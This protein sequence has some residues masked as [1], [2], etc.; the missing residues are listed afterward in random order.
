MPSAEYVDSQPLIS[1]R[2]VDSARPVKIIYIGAGISGIVAGIKFPE[3]IRNLNLTIY[4]K[5]P[6]LGGT[7]YENRYPGCACGKTELSVAVLL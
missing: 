2:S 1:K 3:R 7:W 4:D 6:E 5:N